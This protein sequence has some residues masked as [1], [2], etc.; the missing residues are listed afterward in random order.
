MPTYKTKCKNC[1]REAETYCPLV[2]EEGEAV[3]FC[4]C[5]GI[6]VKKFGSSIAIVKGGDTPKHYHTGGK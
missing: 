5:G 6:L 3:G 1:G 2:S 4:E